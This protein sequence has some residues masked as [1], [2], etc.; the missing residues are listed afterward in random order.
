MYFNESF[1]SLY[2]ILPPTGVRRVLQHFYL[3]SGAVRLVPL[4]CS[5]ACLSLRSCYTDSLSWCW[6]SVTAELVSETSHTL[7]KLQSHYGRISSTTNVVLY[8]DTLCVC[9]WRTWQTSSRRSRSTVWSLT[10]S[11]RPTTFLRTATWLKSRR[12]FLRWPAWWVLVLVS[13]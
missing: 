12:H 4:V 9:S 1:K 10:T 13:S 11:S 6:D 7:Q 8:S 5:A 3:A 2:S